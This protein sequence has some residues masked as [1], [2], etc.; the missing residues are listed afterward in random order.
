MRLS[1][2]I[3]SLTFLCSLILSVS[4]SS[5]PKEA[6]QS[7][8]LSHEYNIYKETSRPPRFEVSI[9]SFE[10]VILGTKLDI[11]VLIKGDIFRLKGFDFLI[12]YDSIVMQ[13]RSVELGSA[14]LMNS[15][16]SL[17]SFGFQIGEQ[18]RCGGNACDAGFVRVN[19]V[20]EN[21]NRRGWYHPMLDEEFTFFTLKFLVT[22]DYTFHCE[23]AQINFVWYDCLDNSI[24]FEN[25]LPDDVRKHGVAGVKAVFSDEQL[26]QPGSTFP[27]TSGLKEKC[28]PLPPIDTL[29]RL[30]DFYHSEV[31]IYCQY[32]IDDNGDININGIA[33]EVA[34]YKLFRD[35]FLYGISVFTISTAGQIASTDINGD[36]ETLKLEDLMYLNQIVVGD[37]LPVSNSTFVGANSIRINT[38][39]QR[40][41]LYSEIRIDVIWLQILGETVPL[42]K[43]RERDLMYNYDGTHTN[44]LIF[45]PDG[46]SAGAL[47]LFEYSGSAKVTKVQAATQEGI[48]VIITIS[49]SL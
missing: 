1:D 49:E 27:S 29:A 16:G 37:A 2:Y 3:F 40:M 39:T 21:G 8:W 44:I 14:F 31:K 17:E 30:I 24:Q 41:Y 5:K 18:A 7:P 36:G 19:S 22:N 10:D 33:N 11:P 6:I 4:L 42:S 34:D 26:L 35:F 48:E 23:T 43:S 45:E 20:I 12:R 15:R 38:T 9:T 13:L 47:E 46:F 25:L 32:Y 28:F